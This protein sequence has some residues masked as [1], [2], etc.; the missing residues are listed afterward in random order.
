[1]QRFGADGFIGK[2]QSMVEAELGVCPS[3]VDVFIRGHQGPDPENPEV[4]CDEQATERLAKYKEQVPP[5][6][7]V[8]TPSTQ[9]PPFGDAQGS[10]PPPNWIV[11]SGQAPWLE[12][13]PRVPSLNNGYIIPKD[14]PLEILLRDGN[15]RSGCSLVNR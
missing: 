8:S 5:N 14:R 7:F 6:Y 9:G 3:F 12:M 13:P 1:M 2:E 4:L 10:Q 11:P 15:L